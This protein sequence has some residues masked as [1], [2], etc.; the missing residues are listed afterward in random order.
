MLKPRPESE[1]FFKRL[2][3]KVFAFAIL[4]TLGC[5]LITMRLWHLQVMQ[6]TELANKAENNRVREITLDGLR[7]KILDRNG[8]TLVDNRP[9]FHLSFIPEDMA[10]PEDS[11]RFINER[12]ELD[13]QAAMDEMGSAKPFQEITLKRD[14]NRESV[15]FIEEHKL[16][17][18]GVILSIKPMRNYIFGD[19]GS[20]MLGYLGA[21]TEGQLKKPEFTGFS[22]NDFIGQSGIEKTYETV[23]RGVKGLKRIE[24]DAAGREIEHLGDL[25]PKSGEDLYLTLDYDAQQAAE[26]AFEGK[27]G[28]AVALDP[29]T[30][31][32]LAYISKPAFN[33]NQFAYGVNPAEWKKL[34]EDEYHPLQNRPIQGQYPPGSTYKV[35]MAAAALQEGVVT[36]QTQIHCPGYY[37]LGNRT[38]RCWKKEGHGPMNVH[39]ALVQSCD[40]FF[41]TVGFKMGINKIAAYSHAFGLGEKSG[42]ELFGEKSGLIPTTQWKEKARREKWILGETI[43]CSIGQGYVLAT[44]MQMARMISAVANRGKLVTP[45][46][47]KSYS[48]EGETAES[49]SKILPV[50]PE[51]MEIVR[52][53]LRGV[54]YEPHGT[55]WAI[56]NGPFEYAGKT[57]TAQVIKMKQGNFLKNEELEFKFRDHAWFVAFAPFNDPKIAVAVIAEHAG[58]G[59][60]A[61]APIVRQIIDAYLGKIQTATAKEG[62]QPAPKEKE[63]PQG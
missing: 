26:Q 4:V 13:M 38:Y 46:L 44:P 57:G 22:R 2:R 60:D 34:V 17:L 45:R 14:L 40:V 5:A 36:P 23:L 12:L 16:D 54:V 30:G 7:G 32:I 52:N 63:E 48:Q 53:A 31:D 1:F 11:M 58:H 59:G 33:P 51:N 47:V 42:V 20:H 6:Y 27:M 8:I 29:N 18:P 21:I 24:V 55:A 9:S 39:S 37:T 49:Q 25:P 62:G 56:K 15:A 19:F 50:S 28:G 3:R 43:S 41:Y 35:M 10:R 61:A